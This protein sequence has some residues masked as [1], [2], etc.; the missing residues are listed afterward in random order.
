MAESKNLYEVLGVSK[1]ASESEIKRAYRS[2]SLVYHPDRNSDES[3]KSK[4][5]EISAAYERLGDQAAR[6]EYDAELNSPFGRMGQGF[7]GQGFPGQGPD[8]NEIFS[9]F[10]G[11][12]MGSMG[13]PMGSMGGPMGSMGGPMGSMGMPFGQGFPPG[14]RVF[15]NGQQV[16]GDMRIEK[17]QP[18][19]KTAQITLEQCF[20]GCVVAID[21]EKWIHRDG[22]RITEIETISLNIPAGI[23]ENEIVTLV[24][25]GNAINEQVKGD[26]KVGIKIVNTTVFVR[27]NMDLLLRKR[28]TLKEALCGFSFEIAHLNGKSMLL[29]NFSTIIRPNYK[30]IIPNLGMVREGQASGSLIIEFDIE[31]PETLTAEQLEGLKTL[32]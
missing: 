22:M 16:G 25:A 7:P 6:R 11:G 20:A 26:I 10:F 15:H 14:I 19:I 13:G 9:M 18:I 24:G 29:N 12:P 3:A 31:F 4:F 21:I 23:T 1:D 32:L 8:I 30:K 5:Q 17:P 27:N 2:L 28:L